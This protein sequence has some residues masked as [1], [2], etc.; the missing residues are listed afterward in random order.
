MQDV[1]GIEDA[2]DCINFEKKVKLKGAPA[3]KRI[4]GYIARSKVL[5]EQKSFDIDLDKPQAGHSD[6]TP[7]EQAKFYNDNLNLDDKA[8]WIIVSNF[9]EFR[10]YNMNDL[11]GSRSGGQ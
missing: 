6:Q 1:L 10:I 5:I 7:F 3:P 2:L 8:R 11:L 9:Q 4:D